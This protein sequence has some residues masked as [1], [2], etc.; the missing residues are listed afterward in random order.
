MNQ[1]KGM[2]IIKVLNTEGTTVSNTNKKVMLKS[3]ASFT[4]CITEMINIQVD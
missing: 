1:K 4:D 2:L 3:C